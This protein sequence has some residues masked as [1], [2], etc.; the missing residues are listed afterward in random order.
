MAAGS[1]AWRAQ[2]ISIEPIDNPPH[3]I[4]LVGPLLDAVLLS[5]VANEP[6]WYAQDFQRPEILHTLR[7]MDAR[8]VLAVQDQR[9]CPHRRDIAYRRRFP[10]ILHVVI[11]LT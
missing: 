9:W 11:R 1:R 8:V 5:R 4:D 2:E 6:N 3:Q 7:G 10:V